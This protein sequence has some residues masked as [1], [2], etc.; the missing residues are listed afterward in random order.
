MSHHGVRLDDHDRPKPAGSEAVGQIPEGP[1]E[2]RQ[3]DLGSWSALKAFQPMMKSDDLDLQ[4]GSPSE[5]GNEVV[6]K[7]TNDCVHALDAMACHRETPGFLGWMEFMGGTGHIVP[8]PA[9]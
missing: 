5:A 7:G 2:P 4:I 1:I 9:L 6:E 3:A 8:V